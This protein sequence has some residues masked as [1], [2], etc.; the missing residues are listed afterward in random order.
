MDQ[1][2]SIDTAARSDGDSGLSGLGGA[3]E[4]PIARAKAAALRYL[5]HRPRT[6]LEVRRRLLR[7]FDASAVSAVVREMKESGLIDDAAFAGAWAESRNSRRPRSARAVRR[8]LLSKG[9]GRAGADE[10]VSSLDDEESA[11]RAGL[12]AAQRNAGL[13]DEAFRRRMWAFM[14]RRGYGPSVTR[15]AIER[16]SVEVRGDGA[17]G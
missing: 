4:E 17:Q 15:R 7:D 8:E 1:T 2:W 11:Y 16:L 5:A 13:P 14:Q 10:A 9:V 6:E 3:G 12:P